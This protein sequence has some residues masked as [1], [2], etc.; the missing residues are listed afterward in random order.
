MTMKCISILIVSCSR[1]IVFLVPFWKCTMK[2][3]IL[4]AQTWQR[5]QVY[6]CQKMLELLTGGAAFVIVSNRINAASKK[7]D[8]AVMIEITINIVKRPLI[9][10]VL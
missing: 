8:T 10:M 4:Y 7:I 5:K 9:S 3:A 2:T 6:I 1:A